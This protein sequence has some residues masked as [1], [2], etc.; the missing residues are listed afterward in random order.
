MRIL[1]Q[2]SETRFAEGDVQAIIVNRP[3]TMVEGTRHDRNGVRIIYKAV[4]RN[5]QE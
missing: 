1:G 5:D 4:V 2:V 3:P